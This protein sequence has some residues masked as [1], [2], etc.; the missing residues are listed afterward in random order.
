MKIDLRNPAVNYRPIPFWSWNDRLEPDELRRQIRAMHEAGLGGFFMHA[1][2]GLQTQYLSQEWLECIKAGLEEAGRLG[3]EAWL[4]DEN[5]FPSGFGDGQVNALGVEYQ[6]KYLRY[7]IADAADCGSDCTIAYYTE[8]GE[9]LGEELPAGYSGRVMRCFY[10]INPYYVDNLDPKVVA[11]FIQITHRCYCENLPQELMPYLK[12]VFTD[13]PQLSR[14][15]IL[16]SFVL[17]DEYR[18]AYRRE[19]LEELPWLLLTGPESS[20]VR[21]R[22]WNLTSRLFERS[23]IQQVADFCRAHG[24]LLTGHQ[25]LEETC[26]YQIGPNGSV[27]TQYRHYDIPGIDHL[28]GGEPHAVAMTQLVSVAMQYGRKQILSESFALCGWNFNFSGM[29][30]LFQQQLVHGVNLL[31]QHLC[32]Y[33]LRGLRKRDYPGSWFIHQPWWDE[34]RVVNDRFSRIGMLLGEGR[35]RVEVL[36]LHPLSSAWALF[37]GDPEN[38]QIAAYSRGLEEVTQALEE[39]RIAHHYADEIITA[40]EGRIVSGKFMIGE[41]AYSVVVVPP[42]ANLSREMVDLL[43]K[44][45]AAGGKIFVVRNTVEP[46]KLTIAGEPASRTVRQWF[47]ALPSFDSAAAAAEAVA[48]GLPELVMITENGFPARRIRSCSRQIDELADGRSG[49]FHLIVN[50]QNHHGAKLHVTLPATGNQLEVI[51]PDD[52]GFY[53]LPE[54]RLENGRWIFDYLLPPGEVLLVFVSNSPARERKELEVCDIP[55][56]PVIRKLSSCFE[57]AEIPGNFLTLDRCRYRVD[58]GEWV[59]DDVSVIQ[60]RLLKLR[61]DCRLEMEFSFT[62]RPECELE[63][64]LTLIV[65]NPERFHFELNGQ[66]FAAVDSGYIFDRAFRRIEL[67]AGIRRGRNVITMRTRFHQPPEVYEAIDR[68]LQCETEYN[69]LTF[70]SEIENVYLYGDFTVSHP[71][72]VEPLARDAERFHGSFELGGPVRSL[73][74]DAADLTA[75]GLPFFAGRLVLRQTFTLNALEAATVRYLRWRLH[76]AN[77]CRVRINGREAGWR[78]SDWFALPVA[79]LCREGVNS[80]EI[81]L[82]T[83]LRNLLGPHHLQEGESTSVW[84]LSFHREP[85]VI[86]WLPEPYDPGYC[87][88]RL[89]IDE[90]ELV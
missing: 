52:G 13:E 3:M 27:M 6:Q 62:A 29:K 60:T 78:C 42:L 72:R 35:A 25:V 75:A 74:L 41:C 46:G 4:Y 83:S 61:R 15:G 20:A 77:S 73:R 69:K 71:G 88:V 49:R 82:T 32:S 31:C 19:L 34:Y 23:F 67:P 22:F 24:W 40:D 37:T 50:Q 2:R 84:P 16:W 9:F 11:R 8:A 43:Q 10:E 38:G 44:F 58:D 68:S 54:A 14:D 28:R 1:R 51:D 64:P 76:G 86:G 53:T 65:E 39:R 18:K 7:E 5:G 70:D 26:Q 30:W 45:A 33:S 47:Q 21:I 55:G 12:G 79:G 89:G 85:N 81:E 17:P 66:P 48:A 80:L 57:L 59:S 87:L 36:V 90:L 56:L 63:A